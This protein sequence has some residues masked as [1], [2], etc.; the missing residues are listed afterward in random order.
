MAAMATT[1]EFAAEPSGE[2][3]YRIELTRSDKPGGG[4]TARVGELP[5]CEAHA[6]T[7]DEAVRA[8]EAAAE[9]WIADAVA[10]GREVP[11]PRS[12]AS[13]SGRLMLRM[14]PSL[15]AELTRA[16][17]LEEASLNQFITGVLASAVEWRSA[18]AHQ[19]AARGP[20]WS[21]TVLLANIVVLAVVGIVALI[22]LII[23]LT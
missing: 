8:V 6:A 4:W 3:A 22:L 21:P 2:T 9:S 18:G 14:P 16:A 15:H 19:A 7:P 17:Q 23:A 11:K 5:G 10:N 12:A 13:H 20:N 1:P